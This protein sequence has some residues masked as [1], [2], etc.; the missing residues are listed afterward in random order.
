MYISTRENVYPC[1][2]QTYKY[3]YIY[4]RVYVE[5]GFNEDFVYYDQY[6]M[7]A[8]EVVYIFPVTA[9]SVTAAILFADVT[10]HNGANGH[11]VEE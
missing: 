7:A 6:S 1:V 5:S 8:H 11:C 10:V 3:L 2:E 9:Y 4:T